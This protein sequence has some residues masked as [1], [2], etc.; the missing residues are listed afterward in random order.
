MW[1]TWEAYWSVIW[2]GRGIVAR[3]VENSTLPFC[4]L[5]G[6]EDNRRQMLLLM[7]LPW[8]PLMCSYGLD[9]SEGE[10]DEEEEG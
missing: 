7:V 9:L 4:V 2:V 5:A 8:V 10:D 6:C 3:V 1:G